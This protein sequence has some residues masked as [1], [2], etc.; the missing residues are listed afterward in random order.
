MRRR[1]QLLGPPTR[2]LTALSDD[3]QLR[4]GQ[5]HLLTSAALP[6][7]C[8]CMSWSGFQQAPGGA[9]MLAQ[10]ACTCRLSFQHGSP[11]T[12]L[13]HGQQMRVSA[14][15]LQCVLHCNR[16]WVK[17]ARGPSAAM[18]AA[19][20]QFQKTRPAHARACCGLAQDAAP[21]GRAGNTERW[22]TCCPASR[23]LPAG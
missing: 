9:C 8:I 16:E 20:L 15:W 3:R 22:A 6:P 5:R 19:D 4:G 21:G 14:P 7:L 12:S 2:P 1:S 10:P 17:P 23:L 18:Q 11:D 13:L